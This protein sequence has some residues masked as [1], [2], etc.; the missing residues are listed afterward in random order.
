MSPASLVAWLVSPWHALNISQNAIL[1]LSMPLPHRSSMQLCG[2]ILIF[3][4]RI[5]PLGDRS[6]VN[7]HG[8]VRQGSCGA[9]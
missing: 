9:R 6:G 4:A 8:M 3:I 2:R 7:L 5:Y 1:H